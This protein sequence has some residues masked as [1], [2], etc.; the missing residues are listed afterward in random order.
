MIRDAEIR[1]LSGRAGVEPRIVELD[2]VL[3]WALGGIARNEY[4]SRRLVFKGG[5]SL[6][7]A[8]GSPRFSDDLDFSA[9][10]P[11]PEKDFKKA[12]LAAARNV[13]EGKLVEALA[14]HHTLFAI[15]QFGDNG[16]PS[17][18]GARDL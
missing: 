5:T 14:K 18:Y 16:F 10:G 13:P 2:Y 17:A 9:L 3:G 11:I 12:S 1:R 7:L 8:Y 15:F 6:R 4:L